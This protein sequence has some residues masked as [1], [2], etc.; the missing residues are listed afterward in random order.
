[1]KPHGQRHK[2][3]RCQ[4]S[5]RDLPLDEAMPVA[6]IRE[7]LLPTVKSMSTGWDPAG[8]VG[9]NELNQARTKHVEELLEGERGEMR[10]LRREVLRSM[11]QNET[12]SRN[13]DLEF[14]SKLTFGQRL[15][16]KIAAF[17]GSWAFILLFLGIILA[18]VI[19]NSVALLRRPFDPYPFILL[20]LVLSCLAALQAP[21]IMMSQN[22][23]E[24]KDRKRGEN[25]YRINL[26]AELEIRHLNEKV[27]R[28]LNE[29]WKHLLEIQQ[30]QMDMIE[31]V[32]KGPKPS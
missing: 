13:V 31:E 11:L 12:L 19:V 25:D 23:Q 18:W 27:D 3:V 17:G 2:T 4:I 10:E 7:S 5:G 15:S 26:R 6:L 20:N 1:M 8:Y 30:M 28:L 16:D 32:S 22:R 29:Q 21:V 9:V 24:A 14:E